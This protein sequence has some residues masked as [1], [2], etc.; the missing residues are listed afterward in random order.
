MQLQYRDIP[1]ACSTR[2]RKL[3]YDQQQRVAASLVSSMM[4]ALCEEQGGFQGSSRAGLTCLCLG[5]ALEKQ[6]PSVV[7][8]NAFLSSIDSLANSTPVMLLP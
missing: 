8:R 5:S 2:W 7:S 6:A 4:L 3:D 1:S